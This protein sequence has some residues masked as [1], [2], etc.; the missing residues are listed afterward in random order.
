MVSTCI[1]ALTS[2]PLSKAYSNH[3]VILSAFLCS[4]NLLCDTVQPLT[5]ECTLIS[6]QNHNKNLFFNPKELWMFC[7]QQQCW[8]HS[9]TII[10]ISI[11]PSSPTYPVPG[12]GGSSLSRLPSSQRPF[13]SLPV[14]L[15][16]TPLNAEEECFSLK[17]IPSGRAPHLISKAAPHHL[18]EETYF[19]HL[20]LV[21][22]CG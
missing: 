20:Y 8:T 16:L 6:L 10:S 18:A 3:V 15:Q 19:C 22:R 1:R 7:H 5:G 2:L 11:H 14:A 13:K 9:V 12:C 17:L 4:P 21:V